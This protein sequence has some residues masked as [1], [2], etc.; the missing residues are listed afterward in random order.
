MANDRTRLEAL[1][2]SLRVA[3]PHGG[4]QPATAATAASCA[5]QLRE[6]ADGPLVVLGV[7]TESAAQL[8]HT[9]CD[10]SAQRR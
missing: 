5:L 8:L 7:G 10:L 4:A 9:V 2:S 6:L 1:G 3:A